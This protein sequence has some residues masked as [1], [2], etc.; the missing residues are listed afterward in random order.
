[1]YQYT[2]YAELLKNESETLLGENGM[3]TS[4]HHIYILFMEME[5]CNIH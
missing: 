1:M 2:A 5:E 3:S 4:L